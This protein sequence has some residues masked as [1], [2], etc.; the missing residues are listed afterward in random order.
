MSRVVLTNAVDTYVSGAQPTKNFNLANRL[1]VSTGGTGDRIAYMSFSRPFPLGVTIISAKLRVYNDGVWAGTVNLTA[2]RI[3][4]KWSVGKVNYNRRP[5]VT[6]GSVNLAKTGA[7]DATMWE[8][9]VTAIMQAVSN[10][11]SWYGIRLIAD[12]SALKRLHSA[13]SGQTTLRPVLD[14]T[15]SDAPEAPTQMHPS[16]NNVVPLA[17]PLLTFDF[18]DLSGDQTMQSAQVQLN[19][20]DSWAAPAFDSGEVLTSTPQIDLSATAYA[21]LASGAS[22]YWRVRVRDGAGIWS[23]WSQSQQFTYKPKGTVTLT[24]PAAS[25]NNVVNESSPPITWTFSGVQR[26]YSVTIFDTAKPNKA[27]WATGKITGTDQSVTPPNGTITDTTI[28]YGVSVKVWDDQ[29]REQNNDIPVYAEGPAAGYTFKLTYDAATATITGLTATPDT[30][31]PV[32]NLQWSRSTMPDEWVIIRDGVEVD[33]VAG[34]DLLV[35]GTTYAY[36]DVYATGRDTHTWAVAAKVNGKTSANNPTASAKVTLVAPWLMRPDRTDAVM[37]LNP[38]YDPEQTSV[39]ELH[40]PSSDA[41]PILI[42]QSINGYEGSMSGIFFD[43]IVPGV[44]A[45]TM[46]NRFRRMRND[47]GTRLILM[48]VN[49]NVPVVAYNM[50]VKPVAYNSKVGYLAS[51]DFVQVS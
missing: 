38:D 46:R 22:T 21:G 49:E 2:Q 51:F 35:S 18:T 27:L 40:R 34:A 6:G 9:D 31:L 3:S 14:I 24:N 50:S 8:F 7:A 25:P 39:Q 41:P 13:Q 48:M 36:T 16:G 33:T 32:M 11:G 12:G 44:T 1:V 29:T 17:K 4:A 28:N 26:A 10:G 20:T 47:P 45:Q 5:G 37:F 42:T 30:V 23:A 19:P 43:D 15:W